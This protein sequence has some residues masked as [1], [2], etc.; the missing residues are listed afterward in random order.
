[1]WLIRT[2]GPIRVERQGEEIPLG[3]PQ[4]RTVLALLAAS[5]NEVVS[6]ETI[7]DELWGSSPPASARTQIHGIISALRRLLGHDRIATDRPRGY[8][9]RAAADELETCLFHDDLECARKM[10][11]Q[12]PSHRARP[13]C[14]AHSPA[15]AV[16]PSRTCATTPA[17]GW[18]R[19]VSRRWRN[20][21]RPIWI[22]AAA[23]T[24]S[25]S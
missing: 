4:T 14:V 12:A 24:W 20:G 13:G 6:I 23:P 7:I 8:R 18:R 25:A 16:P 2:L 15:G 1:M 22:W 17:A 3:P 19:P 10:L 11:A 5:A 21:W 9:L